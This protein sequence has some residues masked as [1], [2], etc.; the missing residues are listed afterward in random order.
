MLKHVDVEESMKRYVTAG[1]QPSVGPFG[2]ADEKHY[3]ID[4]KYAVPHLVR[5]LGVDADVALERLRNFTREAGGVEDRV[6]SDD[7]KE[8]G[9]EAV[10]RRGYSLF[11]IPVAAIAP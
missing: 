6:D 11:R 10:T 8:V 3:R 1:T 5:D 9:R 2:S 4:P 7:R